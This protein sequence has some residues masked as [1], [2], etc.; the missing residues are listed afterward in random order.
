MGL[1]TDSVLQVHRISDSAVMLTKP[2]RMDEITE[3][4]QAHMKAKGFTLDDVLLE[5]KKIRKE[6]WG[7][8]VK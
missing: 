1:Q 3:E 5:L 7:K 2:D 8:R 4:L 6:R